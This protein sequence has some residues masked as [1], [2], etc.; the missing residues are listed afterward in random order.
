MTS[1]RD[2]FILLK[3][4]WEGF[5][6]RKDVSDRFDISMTQA[7]K[8]FT[9]L[10]QSHA[11]ALIYDLSVRRY[12]PGPT[13]DRSCDA[14]SFDEYQRLCA[15]TSPWL[16]VVSPAK[17][18]VNNHDYRTLYQAIENE[19]G[20]NVVYQSLRDPEQKVTR[21]IFPCRI[22]GSGFRWHVR[23]YDTTDQQFKDFNISRFSTI[24]PSD[25]VSP[26]EAKL[27]KD[28]LWQ[29]WITVTLTPNQALNSAQQKLVMLDY[30]DSPGESVLTFRCRAAQLLYTLHRYEVTDFSS[31]PRETQPLQIANLDELMMYL[32]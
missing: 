24:S 22:I 1:L 20:V 6:S 23:A 31:T 10:K 27:T 19:K 12:K 9:A 17:R 11:G 3:T 28:P 4:Y 15:E 16:E 26:N 18:A 7:T 2:R 30:T 8:D 5:V 21:L 25:I 14:Y 32:R 29:K 13:L